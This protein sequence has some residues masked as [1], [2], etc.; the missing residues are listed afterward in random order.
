MKAPVE[1]YLLMFDDGFSFKVERASFDGLK[2]NQLCQE[3][4][5]EGDCGP[6]YV[7][8]IEV[9]D[10]PKEDEDMGGK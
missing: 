4:N 2:L 6:Y 9:E 1:I 8:K 7:H 10:V 3:Y 5:G